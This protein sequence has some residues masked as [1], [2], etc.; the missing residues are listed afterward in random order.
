MLIK[1]G[2]GNSRS[3]TPKTAFVITLSKLAAC[4]YLKAFVPFLGMI[5][6]PMRLLVRTQGSSLYLLARLEA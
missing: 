4:A 5:T 3:I 6:L 1:E 2:K